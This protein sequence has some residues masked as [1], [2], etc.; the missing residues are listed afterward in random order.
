VVA[1]GGVSANSYLRERL[2]AA[3]NI[4]AV[5]PSMALCTDNGAMIAGLAYHLL[6]AGKT[7]P[8][9][10]NAAARVPSFRKAYP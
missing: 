9:D 1:G 8:L 5:F 10:L 4:K 3:E 2:A 6:K 7:S